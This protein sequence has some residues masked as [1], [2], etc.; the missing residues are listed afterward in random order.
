MYEHQ[1][2][3]QVDQIN[4]ATR[5][6]VHG[7]WLPDGTVSADKERLRRGLPLAFQVRHTLAH[8]RGLVTKNDAARFRVLGV[9]VTSGEYIDTT[10][11]KLYE[12]LSEF[13]TEA[14]S[15]FHAWCQGATAG[16]L[17]KANKE[18]AVPLPIATR[19]AVV[20][21]IGDDKVFDP[22]PWVS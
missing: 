8:N 3:H 10:K 12:A 11:D 7:A 4:E 21:V 16:Y 18:R 1:L 2:F 6:L 22:L 17:T 20:S 13:V 5:Q 9:S 19:T 15:S 14:M